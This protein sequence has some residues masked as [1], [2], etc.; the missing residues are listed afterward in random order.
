MQTK[1][2]EKEMKIKKELVIALDRTGITDIEENI[3]DRISIAILQ[4]F[5]DVPLDFL[6]EAINEGGLGKYGRSYRFSVQEICL[7][8]YSKLKITKNEVINLSDRIPSK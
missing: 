4:N 1:L 3:L 6:K 7:W 2:Q 5:K 8:I